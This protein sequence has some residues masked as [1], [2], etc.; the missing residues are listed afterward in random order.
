MFYATCGT[1][2]SPIH[3]EERGGGIK[4]KKWEMKIDLGALLNDMEKG[5]GGR[6]LYLDKRESSLPPSR[7]CGLSRVL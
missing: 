6:G 2:V 3:N 1:A 5:R 7:M 4:M